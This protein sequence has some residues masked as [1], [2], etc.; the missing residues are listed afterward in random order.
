MLLFANEPWGVFRSLECAVEVHSA[1]S[2]IGEKN[3]G[4]GKG[5]PLE[6]TSVSGVLGR[7][8]QRLGLRV[9]VSLFVSRLICLF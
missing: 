9:R 1:Q 2:H 7:L 4:P 6:R 8:A 3:A 5:A